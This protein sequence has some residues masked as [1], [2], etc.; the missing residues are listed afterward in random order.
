MIII[1]S[2]VEK[3]EDSLRWDRVWGVC[4][5]SAKHEGEG[6]HL[7]LVGAPEALEAERVLPV[8]VEA[9]LER[10]EGLDEGVVFDDLRRH[11]LRARA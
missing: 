9:F 2:I 10:L 3:G 11:L 8:R 6:R 4:E 5:D 7:E 1:E